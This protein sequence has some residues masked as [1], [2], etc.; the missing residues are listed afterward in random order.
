MIA[1]ALLSSTLRT[2]PPTTG[3]AA[4]VAIFIPGN[5]T[6]MPYTAV[7]LTFAGVSSR[8]AGVPIKVKS[9]GSLSATSEG[10]GSFAALST[11]APYASLRPVGG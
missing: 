9:F 6:S 2:L 3:L 7:P 10:T 4:T 8:F 1:F 11:S 5:R